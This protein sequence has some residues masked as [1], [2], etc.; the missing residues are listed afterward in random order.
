MDD[1]ETGN[2]EVNRDDVVSEDAGELEN[3]DRVDERNPVA[4][5]LE[6]TETVSETDGDDGME[7]VCEIME[8][9]PDDRLP[10]D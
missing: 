4:D 7:L 3:R 9:V 5:V 8:E 2:A 1:R 10:L 6:E